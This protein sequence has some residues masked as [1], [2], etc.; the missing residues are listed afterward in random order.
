ML[1]E[2]LKSSYAQYKDDTDRFATWLLA[3]AEKCGHQANLGLAG[4]PA[5]STNSSTKAKAKAK[6]K[7]TPILPLKYKAT[8]S[9]LRTLGEVV[10]KSSLK[11][12][13][14]ILAVAR[15]A[16]T[17]RKHATLWFLGN[18][19]SASNKRHA[20]FVQV[21]EEICESLEW[22]TNDPSTK[23]SSDPSSATATPANGK[24]DADAAGQAWINQFAVLSVEEPEDIL[25]QSD[26]SKQLARVEVVQ[27]DDVDHKDP[28]QIHLSHAYFRAFCLFRDLHNM[29]DFM[30]QT[31]EEYRDNKL[32]L[33]T[34]SV[35][36]DTALQLAR[37]AIEELVQDP[38]IFPEFEDDEMA[39]QSMLY[40]VTCMARG[41][42]DNA[43]VELDLP[44]NVNAAETAN[45]FFVIPQI[46]L[47]SF[48]PI[49]QHDDQPDMIKGYFGVVDKKAD[50]SRMS[51]GERLQ[52]DKILLLEL[53]PEFCLMKT[54]G[55]KWPV[56]DEITHGFIEYVK[57]K[58]PKLWHCFAAQILLDIYHTLRLNPAGPWNDLRMAGVRISKTIADFKTL[59]A[60]HPKPAFWP[61]EGDQEIDNI[62]RCID[63]Y[64]KRDPQLSLW[65]YQMSI[66]THDEHFFLKSNPILCGLLM[67]QLTSRMQLIGQGLV[68]QWYDVQQMAFLYN[69]AQKVPGARLD[70]PDIEAFIKIHG[71]N[72]IFVGDR[73]KNAAES[74]NRLEAATG[75]SSV[76]RFARDA[77]RTRNWHLPDGKRNRLL[78]PTTKV[79]NM[80]RDDYGKSKQT[81]NIANADF[82]KL[83]DELTNTSATAKKGTR[84]GGKG[85]SLTNPEDFLLRKW[86]SKHSLGALQFLALVRTKL[87]EEEPVLMFNYF[88]MHQRSVEMLRR[89]RDKE[90]HKFVQYF[91]AGY[92]PDDS[93][94]SNLVI[95]IHH[96]AR[97]SAAASRELGLASDRNGNTSVSRIIMSCGDVMREYLRTKGDIACKEL[98][99]F[100]KNK[101]PLCV[102]AGEKDE[103]EEAKKEFMHIIGLEEVLDPRAMASLMTGIPI[104]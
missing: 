55:L 23:G 20:H 50:R 71:E 49:M 25:E 45:W 59:S 9:E 82:G 41:H 46:L 43:S 91:T 88:G 6:A 89:I 104:A 7:P 74:L 98:R 80:F 62:Q 17:L 38:S 102:D 13:D 16:V 84:R 83:L 15:R 81:R 2:S 86:S 19:N 28:E 47:I 87:H 58:R 27:E 52:E 96:V 11:I 90:H 8:V 54:H 57:A 92:M 64:I 99:T 65:H 79:A 30:L 22:R 12:P 40:D 39:L 42:Y 14:S 97:G 103:D 69:L 26:S 36:T 94:I 56:Q 24:T 34:A 1:P 78:E 101:T 85:Q 4:D 93:W 73:P 63:S 37:A 5:S 29:R 66:Q 67:F 75:I 70:W 33:M 68:N 35:V 60:T 31:W 48:I 76:T 61:K 51:V 21:L 95:L 10:A 32:D 3:A 18:G 44:F 100:C 53:L 77:R 72:R